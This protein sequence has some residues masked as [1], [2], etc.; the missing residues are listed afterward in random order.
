M[1]ARL[2]PHRGTNQTPPVQ[3]LLQSTRL[4]F[5]I[6]SP[7][8]VFLGL[9]TALATGATVHYHIL[10]LILLV[11]ISAHVSVNTLNEYH[12]F[13][14][15]LDFLTRKTLFSGGS[16]A[17]PAN[18]EMAGRVL[19]ASAAA[20]L[21]TL[22]IG[23]YFVWLRGLPAALIGL[24][25]IALILAYTSWLTRSPWACL[26]APGLGFGLLIVIGTHYILTGQ[27]CPLAWLAA[28]VP[29]FLV[30][31]LLLLNQFPDIEADKSSGRRHFPIAHGLDVSTL[32]YGAFLLSTCLTL[33]IGMGTGIFPRLS[34]IA[35]LP[36]LLSVFSLAGAF[37]HSGNIGS[38]PQYLAVNA[39]TTVTAPLLLGIA[40]ILG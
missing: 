30:N 14:S 16:G 25:G 23:I 12:D 6:L 10:A 28:L 4:P 34:M 2:S 24:A 39:A 5:L 27:F 18:P 38:F 36:M 29:F 9:S 37:K 31:N 8:C 7:V 15:G 11:A 20:L 22:L 40:I 32:V 3:V 21:V 13:R 17:L 35:L 26:L 19:L 33:A 1:F